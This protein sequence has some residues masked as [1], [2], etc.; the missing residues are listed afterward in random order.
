MK[1][2]FRF[3]LLSVILLIVSSVI[4]YGQSINENDVPYNWHKCT[5][6]IPALLQDAKNQLVMNHFPVVSKA[7]QEV[8]GRDTVYVWKHNTSVFNP[9][10]EDV[11]VE[12]AGAFI[13][14]KNDWTLRVKYNRRQF[15]RLFNCPKGIL[16]PGEPYTF[17][18]NWR[19]SPALF[20]GYGLWYVKGRTA[21]GEEWIGHAIVLT[22]DKL[23]N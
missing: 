15:S 8:I 14:I 18:K 5:E 23:L 11:I 2:R 7:L 22:I 3:R 12:E 17:S 13:F 16:L 1:T 10:E 19:K 4:I 6:A 20:E 21:D 9:T